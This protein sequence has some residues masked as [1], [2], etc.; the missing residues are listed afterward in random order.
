[1]YL[2]EPDRKSFHGLYAVWDHYFRLTNPG[3]IR[4]YSADELQ[5]LMEQAGF[6]KVEELLR[7]EKVLR[8]GKLLASAV[9]LRGERAT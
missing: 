4:Y 1:M 3:H 5:G 2:L 8:G 9:I 7:L 6:S